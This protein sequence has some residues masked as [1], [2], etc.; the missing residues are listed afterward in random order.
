MKVYK[1]QLK[2][3]MFGT[4]RIALISDVSHD[5]RVISV[6]IQD[7][8]FVP[9]YETDPDKDKNFKLPIHLVP[10]GTEIDPKMTRFIS[11]GQNGP[12]VWHF[13]SI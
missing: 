10:T 2:L 8:Y 12:L 11:T 9:W 1:Q 5:A 13:Y 6:Q 4:N 3:D 7:G